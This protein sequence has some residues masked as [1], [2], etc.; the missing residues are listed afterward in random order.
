MT[1]WKKTKSG[2]YG[3][4]WKKGKKTIV[5]FYRPDLK[6]ATFWEGSKILFEKQTTTKGAILKTL[7]NW[8]GRY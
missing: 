4:E 5:V 6:L 8:K 1:T 3:E 7:K 2:R